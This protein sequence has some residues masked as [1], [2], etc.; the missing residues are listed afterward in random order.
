MRNWFGLVLVGSVASAVLAGCGG[1]TSAEGTGPALVVLDRE[2]RA[3]GFSL[4]T[5]D[6]KSAPISPVEITA[7]M[8]LV[9]PGQRIPLS[10]SPGEIVVVTGKRGALVPRTL[11][12][13]VDADVAQVEGDAQR[14]K[15]LAVALHARVSGEGPFQLRAPGI[16]ESLAHEDLHGIDSI[17]P[18]DAQ[19]ETDL[20]A[21][22]GAAR[23]ATAFSATDPRFA[24]LADLGQSARTCSD[25][26]AGTWRSVPKH[27]SAY[28][29]WA[30][31]T[32]H[33][34]HASGEGAL[35]AT[36]SAHIWS[37]GETAF[38][39]GACTEDGLDYQVSMPTRGARAPD[40]TVRFDAG[41]W[42]LD[43]ASC[44]GAAW[45]YNPDHFVGVADGRA[46][47]SVDNDG[48]RSVNDPF[49]FERVSCQ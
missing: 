16:L 39:P 47:R 11:G 15:S 22:E 43:T 21:V 1:G 42:Q 49:G 6:G 20:L 31:M 33:V 24:D 36:L 34:E 44:N 38:V 32:L 12:S 5:H 23:A 29:D 17:A 2:A 37:G 8:S 26:I 13:D 40:G 10:G 7:D 19:P 48:G 46:L 9:G 30:V 18:V 4:V 3:A 25:P 28:Q 14:I 41:P 35:T 45:G 27:Y